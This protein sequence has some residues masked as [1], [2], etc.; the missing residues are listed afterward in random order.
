MRTTITLDPDVA[1][2]LEDY[3]R[4][5]RTTFKQAVNEALRRGLTAQDSG[6]G[7]RFVVAPHGGGFLPG[8]DPVRLKQQL[9]DEE[10]EQFVRRSAPR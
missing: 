5:R 7:E 1:K 3:A 8:V 9:D 2:K 6:P 10:A 4:A